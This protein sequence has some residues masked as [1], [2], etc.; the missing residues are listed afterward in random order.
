MLSIV[1]FL[2]GA[3]EIVRALGL[4]DQRVGVTAPGGLNPGLSMLYQGAPPRGAA[5]PPQKERSAC[6]L[7]TAI[8]PDPL[9][10]PVFWR[11][12]GGASARSTRARREGRP[13][14]QQLAALPAL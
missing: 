4:E 13:E 12:T 8:R 1:S 7:V 10:P 11:D 6:G 9:F 5:W 2:P 3:T 14:R